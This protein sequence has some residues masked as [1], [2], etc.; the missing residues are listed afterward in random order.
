MRPTDND[1][2]AASL[3]TPERFAEIFDRHYDAIR[4]YLTR[5]LGDAGDDVAAETFLQAFPSRSRYRTDHPDARP[6]W[7][8]IAVRQASRHRRTERRHLRQLPLHARDDNDP[9]GER[10]DAMVSPDDTRALRA[11]LAELRRDERDALTLHVL[12]GLTYDEAATALGVAPG[13]V[14]SGIHRARSRLRSRVAPPASPAAAVL[15]EV[16]DA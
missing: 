10:A 1:V 6:W 15:S 7:Y 13:T 12:A 16:P 8:G 11:G 14:A 3:Q 9:G 5:R 4:G 2:I